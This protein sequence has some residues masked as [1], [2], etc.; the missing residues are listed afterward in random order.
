VSDLYDYVGRNRGCVQY[1]TA[2]AAQKPQGYDERCGG[3]SIKRPK[4]KV[5]LRI[6]DDESV[7]ECETAFL[8]NFGYTIEQLTAPSDPGPFRPLG[9][10][11]D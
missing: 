4:G 6:D 11:T 5:I 2:C 3:A 1:L 8:G 7:L 10:D 9:S